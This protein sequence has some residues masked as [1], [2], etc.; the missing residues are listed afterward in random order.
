MIEAVLPVIDAFMPTPT[1]MMVRFRRWD[2]ILKSPQPDQRLVFTTTLWHFARGM[3]FASTGRI[4]SAEKEQNIVASAV[5]GFPPDAMYGPLNR[6]GSV[7][8]IAENVLSAKIATAKNDKRTAV[9]L[10]KKALAIQDLLNYDEPE[11]WYIPVRES[12][13]GA[14]GCQSTAA[15]HSVIFRPIGWFCPSRQSKIRRS[16]VADRLAESVSARPEKQ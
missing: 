10:L 16:R 13:G 1:L 9:A 6:A 12:L 14:S 5:R 15:C 3:A 11:D 7:F 8:G 4:E 2:D